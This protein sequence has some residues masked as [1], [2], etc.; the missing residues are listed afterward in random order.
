MVCVGVA[1]SQGHAV[2]Q[3][4]LARLLK[5]GD[6]VTQDKQKAFELYCTAAKQGLAKAQY[7]IG[8]M[9]HKGSDGVPRDAEKAARWF[10]LA[11]S[12]GHEGSLYHLTEMLTNGA[13][14]APSVCSHAAPARSSRREST[15]PCTC[16][17]GG[18]VAQVP[19]LLSVPHQVGS[20]R[21]LGAVARR[22]R[23]ARA[24]LPDD[25]AAPSTARDHVPYLCDARRRQ[26]DAAA[27]DG[28]HT[29]ALLGRHRRGRS[30]ATPKL[31]PIVT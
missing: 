17:L 28:V 4:S 20:G 9:Y 12:Q 23:L 1:A 26:Q 24:V 30:Q 25:A 13:S 11:V 5:Y 31:S 3:T 16:R 19:S 27:F 2:A 10:L 14:R 18:M 21:H 22:L 6:G 15:P 7:H 29:L 8:W